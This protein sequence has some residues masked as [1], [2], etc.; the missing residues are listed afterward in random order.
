MAKGEKVI[1]LNR[2]ARHDYE[3]I[4]T[5]EAGIELKG[6]EVKSLR[7]GQVNLKDSYARVENGEI[8]LVGCHISPYTHGSVFNHDPLRPRRLL[9]H[10]DEIRRIERK[11]VE[12]GYTL[13]PLSL[14]FK[15]GKVKVEL[16]LARGKTLVDKRETI[17]RKTA[18]RE[19]ERELKHYRYKG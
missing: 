17:K 19:I 15:R 13:I 7:G 4:E 10:K 14:Y 9:L 5:I 1:T 12:R 6:S 2:R 3:I 8:W 11:I 16:A 18:K